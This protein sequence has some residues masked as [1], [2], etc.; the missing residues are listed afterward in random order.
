[1]AAVVHTGANAQCPRCFAAC[2]PAAPQCRECGQRLSPLAR[3]P[4]NAAQQAATSQVAPAEAAVDALDQ[5]P[6]AKN[7]ST[8]LATTGFTL[9]CGC[10]T[11]LRL[12]EEHRG[13]KVRCPRCQTP[14]FVPLTGASS[15]DATASSHVQTAQAISTATEAATV[16]HSASIKLRSIAD[17]QR[18]LALVAAIKAQPAQ[19][20]DPPVL[21]HKLG[22]RAWAK[23][24]AE[25]ADPHSIVGDVTVFY[26][27]WV[28][29]LADSGDCRGVEQIIPLMESP[30]TQVRD[31]AIAALGQFRDP[32][33]VPGLAKL[34]AEREVAVRE[35]AVKALGAIRDARA[36][37]ALIQLGVQDP[38]TRMHVHQ[39]IQQIGEVAVDTLVPLLQS[40]DPAVALSAAIALGHWP[41]PAAVQAVI[42]ILSHA[43]VVVRAQAIESL[44]RMG[45]RRAIP[46]LIQRLS[47]AEPAV[48]AHAG[49][50]LARLP[51]PK[52]V[53]ALLKAATDADEDVVTA[54][55]KALAE[56]ADPRAIPILRALLS[57]TSAEIRVFAAKG[58]GNIGH[59]ETI[60]QLIAAAKDTDADVRLQAI[61]AL[62]SFPGRPKVINQLRESLREGAA[63]LRLKAVQV[64]GELGAQPA[65]EPLVQI[66]LHDPSK[67]VRGA[68]ARALGQL[69][70]V[71]C[72]PALEEAVHDESFVRCQAIAAIARI[73]DASSLPVL[74]ALLRD[75]I[76]ETQ[77]H[78]ALALGEL[79]HKNAVRPLEL[80]LKHEHEL[81]RRGA[82]KALIKLGHPRSDKLLAEAARKRRGTISQQIVKILPGPVLLVLLPDSKGARLVSWGTLATVLLVPLIFLWPKANPSA[83]TVPVIAQR[84]KVS[85]VAWTAEGKSL[86]V[87]RSRGQIEIWDAATRKVPEAIS[88][89]TNG[90]V[91][92][93]FGGGSASKFLLE[94][95]GSLLYRQR[96]QW[97]TIAGH[98]K[99]I[100]AAQLSPNGQYAVTLGEDHQLCVW[101]LHEESLEKALRCP[102]LDARVLAIANDASAIALGGATGRICAVEVASNKLLFDITL[103]ANPAPVQGLAFHPN[104]Q[105]LAA[106]DAH[107]AVRIS[108]LDGRPTSQVP[109]PGGEVSPTGNALWFDPGGQPVLF[110]NY[111]GT[112]IRW[113]LLEKKF[114]KV[115]GVQ[116][117]EFFSVSPDGRR[118]ATGSSDDTFVRVFDLKTSTESKLDKAD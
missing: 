15:G 57:H 5:S 90:A 73:G 37:P 23:L 46:G 9:R 114:T 26:R 29:K 67:E 102:M 4:Q 113:E 79:G 49:Q 94:R 27:T 111:A 106:L 88:T 60:D 52:A 8:P 53:L 99:P 116:F 72:L 65:A 55:A 34:L 84:G 16:N 43:T 118:I 68:A 91:Q 74:L 117:G 62:R 109:H 96:D 13:K 86:I 1:M 70:Q 40:S 95:D 77:H 20:A 82:A 7:D 64:L 58:L 30:R 39:A 41:T 45:D 81:V 59:A 101:N 48:R 112:L 107:G 10:S 35:A 31:A 17:Q 105:R 22:K 100:R 47:D 66:L 25:V 6:L 71:Q 56:L 51:D 92:R 2:E 115:D 75:P 21:A 61:S 38:Q 63:P 32:A 93:V 12:R 110:V 69:R 103:A 42:S 98:E 33:A 83:G 78:A 24:V 85:S 18:L 97:E 44:S 54:A 11:Q 50:A 87:G 89:E 108:D 19:Q 36:V 14:L 104:G 28:R 80:M 3:A 76:P